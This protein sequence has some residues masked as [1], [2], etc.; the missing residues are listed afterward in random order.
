MA[1]GHP[2]L[3]NGRKHVVK[4]EG[5]LLRSILNRFQPIVQ[6][7]VYRV[8]SAVSEWTKPTSRGLVLGS[9]TD[10]ARS[11]LQLVAENLLLR[12]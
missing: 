6:R 7:G 11:K 5:M 12:H 4:E 2:R 3:T 9:I 1:I 8:G 10:L